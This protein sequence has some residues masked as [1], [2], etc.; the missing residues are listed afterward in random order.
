MPN[1]LKKPWDA[2]ITDDERRGAVDAIITFFAEERDEEIGRVAATEV[3]DMF[4]EILGPKIFNTGLLE[5]K[6]WMKM[7]LAEVEG[8]YDMLL[9]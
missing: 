3:L 8:E 7:K 5:G 4:L 9:K 6:T 1:T 2:L